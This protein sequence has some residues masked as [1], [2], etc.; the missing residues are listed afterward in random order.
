[1]EDQ[2]TTGHG[3]GSIRALGES[4][5]GDQPTDGG[6][7]AAGGPGYGE[8]V[9]AVDQATRI[10]YYLAEEPRG[11]MTLTEICRA[12]G[13]Y[14]S[15]G[16]AILNTLRAA[17]LITRNDPEKTYSLGPGLLV[18]SR[19]LLDQ[20]DLTRAA[21]PFLAELAVLPGSCSFLALIRG[22][23]VYVVARREAPGGVSVTIRVGYHYPLTWGS[24][25]KAIVASLPELERERML[26]SAPL[27]FY[28]DPGVAGLDLAAV[29]AELDEGRRLG[30]YRDLGAI[31]PGLHAVSA[32]V[33]DPDDELPVGVLTLVGTFPAEE[34]EL[35]GTR[36]E[37]KAREMGTLLGPFLDGVA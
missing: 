23:Q 17:D 7:P 13:I 20:T 10:L 35:H 31:Q 18:L 4:Y 11:Q 26:V 32:P 21:A 30:Y 22:D 34:V 27:Y 16:R 19:A 14:K 25:G 3:S 36:V 12:V 29:R 6:A 33:M 2:T 8:K 5:C 24:V 37:A 9:P 28:G 15:K 1:M